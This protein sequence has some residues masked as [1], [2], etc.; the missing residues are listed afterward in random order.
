MENPTTRMDLARAR[1]IFLLFL[2]EKSE[3]VKKET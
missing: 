2:M 1:T 3:L